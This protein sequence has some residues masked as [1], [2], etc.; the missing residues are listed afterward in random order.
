MN[1]LIRPAEPHDISAIIELCAEHAE[2]EKATYSTEGKAEK[3]SS[4]LF[5]PNPRLFCLV[6]EINQSIV[7][8]TTYMKEFS[9]W[10]T[11]FYIHMDCLYLKPEARSLGIGEEFVRSIASHALS[12]GIMQIQWQTPDFNERAIK[13]YHRIGAISKPKFRMFLNPAALFHNS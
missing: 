9:T 13:F 2:Y 4:F 10:D 1:Y 6:A 12:L 3:L 8:Y 11:D 7:G 5:I